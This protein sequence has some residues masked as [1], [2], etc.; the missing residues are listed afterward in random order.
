MSEFVVPLLMIWIFS[1]V[2]SQIVATN[3]GPDVEHVATAVK[4]NYKRR[5]I[6]KSRKTKSDGTK[7][8]RAL[9]SD[10]N[11]LFQENEVIIPNKT[12]GESM[13]SRTRNKIR[14]RRDK[15]KVVDDDGFE[16]LNG[17]GSSPSDIGDLDKSPLQ[18]ASTSKS[19]GIRC[20][21]WV[22]SLPLRRRQSAP[23]IRYSSIY[24][25]RTD[26]DSDQSVAIEVPAPHLPRTASQNDIFDHS[27]GIFV[28]LSACNL[29]ASKQ[30][31][32]ST[33]DTDEE[34]ECETISSPDT[35]TSGHVDPQTSGNE[36]IP[37]G[38]TTNS[39]ECSYSSELSESDGQ[40]DIDAP[41]NSILS[42]YCGPSGRVSC[43][44]WDRKEIKKADLSVV[45]ISS[46]IIARVETMPGNTD[47]FY[48]GMFIT[49]I[50]SIL[51][52]L[53]RFCDKAIDTSSE[54]ELQVTV[55]QIGHLVMTKFT[56]PTSEI[57]A[58]FF[59]T[60]L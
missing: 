13:L 40:Y 36:W 43:T 45:E 4:K 52:L 26:S 28:G 3:P 37:I 39:E 19:S 44:I 58:A 50:I 59:G 1:F 17:Y 8:T 57:F 49:T 22:H 33:C 31:L 23:E 7:R 32:E 30:R 46:V 51:P 47:C 9:R 42:P 18:Q 24:Q 11:V 2:H 35:V 15:S 48:V 56:E 53:C 5:G 21:E 38:L 6:R 41:T 16:S 29:L 14:N 10:K 55:V 12:K 34:G 25:H 54:D 60:Y 27:N 20:N